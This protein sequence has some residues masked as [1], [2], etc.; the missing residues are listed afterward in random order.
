MAIGLDFY[1]RSDTYVGISVRNPAVGADV[2]KALHMITEKYV[3]YY[4]TSV[5][6]DC[7]LVSADEDCIYFEF[8]ADHGVVGKISA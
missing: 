3:N 4:K 8:K 7:I 6:D 1:E 5:S 2:S